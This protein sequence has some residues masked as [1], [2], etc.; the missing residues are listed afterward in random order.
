MKQKECHPLLLSLCNKIINLSYAYP[1][2][3]DRIASGKKRIANQFLNFLLP[4]LIVDT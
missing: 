1:L 3:G 4:Y 2:K